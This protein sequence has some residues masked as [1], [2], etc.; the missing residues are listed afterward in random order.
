[1]IYKI[2]EKHPDKYMNGE[3]IEDLEKNRLLLNAYNKYMDNYLVDKN[4]YYV[5]LLFNIYDYLIEYSIKDEI[6][7]CIF[8]T[9]LIWSGVLSVNKEFKYDTQLNDYLTMSPLSIMNGSG[10]CRNI[11]RMLVDILR[12]FDINAY[13][14]GCNPYNTKNVKTELNIIRKD[15][16]GTILN[17]DPFSTYKKS[18][19]KYVINHM[20]VIFEYNN[21]FIIYDPT[22]IIFYN[23]KNYEANIIAGRGKLF[24]QPF[25]L[26]IYND[27]SYDMMVDYCNVIKIRDVYNDEKYILDS[28][29]RV[30]DID[31]D[32]ESFHEKNKMLIKKISE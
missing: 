29:K 8:I 25:S 18:F 16:N 20:D 15:V 17:N 2:Y 19:N 7:I 24:Y 3:Y 31:V 32:L 6:E 27:F 5:E 28:L 12:L 22:N 13:R 30:L 23:I 9:N 21:Q 26:M 1:M 11:S 10:C 14:I 4:N